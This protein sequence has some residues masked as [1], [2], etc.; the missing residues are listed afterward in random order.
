[1]AP[2][3]YSPPGCRLASHVFD[4]GEP[5]KEFSVSIIDR[6]AVIVL[7]SIHHHGAN[8]GT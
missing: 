6:P 7:S 4:F 2:S 8:S 3:M 5:G 1:M